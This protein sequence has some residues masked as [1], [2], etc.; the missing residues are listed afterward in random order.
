[1]NVK[2]L[3]CTRERQTQC[4]DFYKTLKHNNIIVI[5]NT[6]T[7]ALT[8]T[9][10]T[11]PS[12][13]IHG[14]GRSLRSQLRIQLHL[15]FFMSFI[16]ACVINLLW[17]ILVVNERISRQASDYTLSEVSDH[18]TQA[19][20][21]VCQPLRRKYVIISSTNIVYTATKCCTCIHLWARDVT[22][23]SGTISTNVL[24]C[25]SFA[26]TWERPRSSAHQFSPTACTAFWRCFVFRWRTSKSALCRSLRELLLGRE[27]ACDPPPAG[28]LV[29]WWS[30][31]EM[32]WSAPFCQ[33][34]FL[35]FIQRSSM[36]L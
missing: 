23:Q 18:T 21:Y 33:S 1:M 29:R 9:L 8:C 4:M 24:S 13:R 31:H 10:I 25:H 30:W 3:P 7:K 19:S 17:E 11:Q 6:Y 16:V 5:W 15:H 22:V 14:C 27:S 26:A 28:A 12:M 20:A 2:V 32:L 35:K 36:H 34:M